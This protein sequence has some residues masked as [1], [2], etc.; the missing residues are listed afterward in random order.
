[1]AKT[2]LQNP[3]E[4]VAVGAGRLRLHDRVRDV[5]RAFRHQQLL[6]PTERKGPATRKNRIRFKNLVTEAGKKLS[7]MSEVPEGLADAVDDLDLL[8]EPTN[9]FWQR[10]QDG[11][12][13]V[14]HA[15][16]K[17]DA[18]QVPFCLRAR[19]VIDHQPCL[20]DL[21]RLRGGRRAYLVALDLGGVRVYAADRWNCRRIDLGQIPTS[22]AKATRYDD[23]EESLQQRAVSAGKPSRS[24]RWR[25]CLPRARGH[26]RRDPKRRSAASS[27]SST[28]NCHDIF[29]T[30][31]RP[32]CC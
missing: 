32:W 15:S 3:R 2:T 29:Q 23:P 7:S 17:T 21:L 18:Y 8:D 20:G 14:V 30:A 22:L 1:M 31:K 24:G 6:T 5:R 27:R 4:L 13:V 9:P 28:R 12:A 11:L 10:Q 16:G 19:V 26:R 25:C